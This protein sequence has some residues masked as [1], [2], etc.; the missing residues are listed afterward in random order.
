M[1][2]IIFAVTLG[3]VAFITTAIFY[4]TQ[5]ADINYYQGHR[6]FEKGAYDKAIKFYEQALKI[7]PSYVDALED[8]AYCYQ[9][10]KR[11]EKAIEVFQKALLSKPQDND[12]KISLAETYSWMKKYKKAIPLYEE[13]IR[14]AGAIDTKRQLAEVYIWDNQFKEARE[15]LAE[16]LKIAPQD[17][18]AKLLLAKAMQYSGQAE[19]AIEIYKEL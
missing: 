3:L 15:I 19:Q 14:V 7:K 11:Y 4:N 1:K 17:R 13:V 16:I 8:L 2:I 9:W 6:L 12:L 5:Q 10:T 18:K